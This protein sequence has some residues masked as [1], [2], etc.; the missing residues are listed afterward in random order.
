MESISLLRQGFCFFHKI[1]FFGSEK[2]YNK[3]H[4]KN[5][6]HYNYNNIMT[7]VNKA[8][9]DGKYLAPPHASAW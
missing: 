4:V 7:I 8:I 3:H 6:I 5:K 1:T 9:R 2:S